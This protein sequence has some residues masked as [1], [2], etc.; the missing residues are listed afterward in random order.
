MKAVTPQQMQE[1]DARAI[2]KYRIPSLALMEKAGGAV[3]QKAKEILGR[4]LSSGD[5]CIAIVCGTGN[6]GGDGL[7]A[8]RHLASE[9]YQVQ[10]FILGAVNKLKGDAKVNL[11]KLRPLG[12]KPVEL[13]GA[14]A[15]NLLKGSLE[16]ADLVIDA[17]F[18][19]GFRGEPD[20]N[21]AQVIEL[22]NQSHK[23]VLA[24]DIPSGVDGRTGAC[25]I[26]I[27]A[28]ATVTMGLLKTG[29]LFYPGREMA[30]EV[31]VADIGI[32]QGAV[33]EQ[34][35]L[36]E[37][38]DQ[39][40]MVS[41]LPRRGPDAHKG[42]CGT[43]LVLAGS[44]GLTG[45]AALT[46]LAALRTG[47]GMVYLGIPESLN[48]VMETKLTEVITR[49]LPETRTRTLS[50]AAFD[51][52]RNLLSKA[53]VLA[54]GPGLSTHPETAE[55][56]GLVLSQT[57]I[58]AVIDADALNA[59]AAKPEM[60]YDIKTS[61][62]LT[63]H[64]GEMSRLL[65]REVLQIKEDPLASAQEAAQRFCQ[66]VVLKGAPSVIAFTKEGSWIN[67]TGNAGMATAG[68]GDV[69]TGILAGLLAQGLRT[70]EAA[71]LGV[72][73]H[74]LAGDLAAEDYTPYSLIAGDLIDYLPRAFAELIRKKP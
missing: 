62:I 30:G 72:Y 69:L 49:P 22:I 12:L 70:A 21:C 64:Y 45:A 28:Q 35:G 14:K 25:Q 44:A 46:S 32:P 52:I 57:N 37:Y 61:L 6:N 74:G 55:L 56:V 3:V 8:A 41:L 13:T 9:G 1:I 47:A 5:L 73:L 50:L 16:G 58:P 63:P 27:R 7:V 59:A 15:L 34:K 48:D 39:E 10:V 23:A 19:T 26:G 67:P 43:V 17:I 31:E 51:K 29:L 36:M 53:D 71:K 54:I 38:P 11:E 4:G 20:R 18:G 65:S 24:I 2:K 66:T 40:A 60:L 33:D 42:S 68:S